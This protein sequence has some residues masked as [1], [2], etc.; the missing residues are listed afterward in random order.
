[1]VSRIS[2]W[3]EL[4]VERLVGVGRLQGRVLGR[5]RARR[6]GHPGSRSGARPGTTWRQCAG[7]APCSSG[8][9]ERPSV[10]DG[11]RAPAMASNVGARSVL[12]ASRVTCAPARTPGPR[13]SSGHVDVGLVRG[14]LA[15]R[16]AVLTEVEAVVRREHDVGVVELPGHP[17]RV[18]EPGD[19]A[20]DGLQRPDPL[21]VQRVDRRGLERAELRQVAHEARHAGSRR[22]GRSSAC[23]ARAPA[24]TCRRP[25]GAG[26]RGLVR[27][28]HRE[29]GEERLVRRAP[30]RG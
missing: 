24:G 20:V 19:A 5:V 29:V 18:H 27:R 6:L 12:P 9:S 14:L 17:E 16:H 25:R 8:T 3:R 11:V 13:T 26:R 28:V 23:A 1:M 2:R 30:R 4:A 22:P 21:A 10:N 7:R 15:R